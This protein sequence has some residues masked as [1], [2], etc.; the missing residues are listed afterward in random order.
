MNSFRSK[1]ELLQPDEE[2]PENTLQTDTT[3][4]DTIL[5]SGP[6]SK[7]LWVTRCPGETG[8]PVAYLA[9]SS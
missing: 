4:G 1:R 5:D 9:P 6:E 3:L 8:Q 7:D 2:T